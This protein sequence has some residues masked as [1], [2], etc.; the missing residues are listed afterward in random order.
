MFVSHK[1][2]PVFSLKSML[3][4]LKAF[5]YQSQAQTPLLVAVSMDS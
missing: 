5:N 4:A 3:V 2:E 1:F